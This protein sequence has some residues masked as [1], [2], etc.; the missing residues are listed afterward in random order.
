[1]TSVAH[2]L[3]DFIIDLF[4]DPEKAASYDADP[5]GAL[6]AAGLHDARPHDV[7][8]L[9]PMVA[10]YSTVGGWGGRDHGD[11]HHGDR[12]DVRGDRNDRHDRNDR[13][14]RDHCDDDDDRGHARPGRD[15]DDHD[16]DHGHVRPDRDDDHCEEDEHHHGHGGV[17]PV[18]APAPA[19][20]AG[21]ETVVITHLQTIQYTNTET[22]VEIDA[23][24]SI[25]VSG[26]SQAIFGDVD[27]DVTQIDNEGGVVAGDDIHGDVDNSD[28]SVT[29]SFNTEVDLEDNNLVFGNGNTV[30]SGEG[31][32]AGNTV[33]DNSVDVDVELDDLN[34]N[35]GAGDLVTG[36][37]NA[38]GNTTTITD[39][40]N[41]ES[42]DVEV[43]DV[44]V[45]TG[46][47]NLVNDS[48]NV[49][50]VND[51]FNGNDF[52]TDNSVNDSLNGN[53]LSSTDNSVNDSFDDNVLTDNSVNDSLNGNDL[54]STD[55]SIDDSFDDNDL[56][57][58]DVVIEDNELAIG[59][60]NA[61]TGFQ[62]ESQNEEFELEYEE[63]DLVVVEEVTVD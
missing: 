30:T 45:N 12:G 4:R 9:K 49:G 55:N 43:D 27:G 42:V 20:V 48:E 60:E 51:S 54:S 58:D 36:D 41:D 57:D 61:N 50:S 62:E 31:N 40:L 59:G 35:T 38:V 37:G 15:D 47:G 44:N 32:I 11:R 2:T 28:T 16:R 5:Q 19:P 6:D 23:S 63:G 52:S 14:D 53:D 8:D 46:D 3:L 26:D 17:S 25:W 10:D 22:H 33:T 24:H 56:S 1:M 21:H 34:V 18:T 13:D 7:D 29:D 39:S